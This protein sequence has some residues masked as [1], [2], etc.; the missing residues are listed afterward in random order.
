MVI[1]LF[2]IIDDITINRMTLLVIAFVI[3]YIGTSLTVD[4][5]GIKV[6]LQGTI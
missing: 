5:S 1:I 2:T 6:T 3:G 4:Q